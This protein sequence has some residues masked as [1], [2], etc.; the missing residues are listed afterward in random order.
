[1]WPHLE[2]CG[3]F[4]APQFKKDVKVLECVQR[5]ATKLV[6]TLEG[7]SCEER[8]RT[9]GLSSLEKRRLRGNLIALYSF[10]RMGR[11]EVGAEVFSLGSSNRTC[12]NSSKVHQGKF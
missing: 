6:E 4:W 1:V 12:G 7:M 9:L 10:L 5:K 11:E 8:L 2:C 3:Q